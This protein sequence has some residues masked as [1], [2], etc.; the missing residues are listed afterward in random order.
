M[1][2]PWGEGTVGKNPKKKNS[3]PDETAGSMQLRRGFQEQAELQKEE[4]PT[5]CF[6]RWRVSGHDQYPGKVQALTEVEKRG[7]GSREGG[8]LKREGWLKNHSGTKLFEGRD[9]GMEKGSTCSTMGTKNCR[10]KQ[11]YEGHAGRSGARSKNSQEV[12]NEE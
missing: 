8:E 2:R 9:E 10:E 6:L 1:S 5:V 11:Q 4:A 12:W 3:S 7:K